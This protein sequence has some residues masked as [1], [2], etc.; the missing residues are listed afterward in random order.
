MHKRF[1]APVA[2][3]VYALGA[4]AISDEEAF[5]RAPDDTYGRGGILQDD[6]RTLEIYRKAAEN[7]DIEA[8]N[9]LADSIYDSQRGGQDLAEAV[10]WYRRA[11]EQGSARAQNRLGDI[12]RHGHGAA[13]DHAEALHWYALAAE[14][15]HIKALANLRVMLLNGLG[16]PQDYQGT[17]LWNGISVGSGKHR[18]K[19]KLAH[20]LEQD[21]EA[22]RLLTALAQTGYPGAQS[23][24]GSRYESGRGIPQDLEAALLWYRRGAEGGD[25]SAQKNLAAMYL[26]GMGADHDK[27]QA[28]KWLTVALNLGRKMS[29]F[30][31][32]YF[33]SE[34]QTATNLLTK[35]AETM[36]AAEIAEAEKLA[37]QWLEKHDTVG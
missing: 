8:Q 3:T 24:L 29:R 35:A 26:N 37:A 25:I 7:G 17:G 4:C 27:V 13:Q 28:L 20:M 14:Q 19:H 6:A 36:T 9:N 23:H 11:A 21:A 16:V 15:G 2:L 5:R 33:R 18:G 30:D 12:Y 32:S 22:V 31:R 10:R 1:L 34:I